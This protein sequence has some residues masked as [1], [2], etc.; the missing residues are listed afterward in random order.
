MNDLEVLELTD[1]DLEVSELENL[2]MLFWQ[3]DSSFYITAGAV[4]L[5]IAITFC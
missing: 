3:P 2:D 1:S 4:A 5:A